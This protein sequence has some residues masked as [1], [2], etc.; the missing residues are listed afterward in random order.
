MSSLACYLELFKYTV[1]METCYNKDLGT[2]E[3]TLLYQV[4]KSKEI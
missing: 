3:I 4:S 2:V 1:T